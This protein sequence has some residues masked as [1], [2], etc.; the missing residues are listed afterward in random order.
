MQNV[1]L[2]PDIGKVALDVCES[3]GMIA[4]E[5]PITYADLRDLPSLS[6]LR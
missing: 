6:H 5:D 2:L 4:P 3:I 1:A